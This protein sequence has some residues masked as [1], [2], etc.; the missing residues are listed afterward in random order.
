MKIVNATDSRLSHQNLRA[1]GAGGAVLALFELSG[2]ESPITA[3]HD[4]M[5]RCGGSPG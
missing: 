3:R 2:L 1:L 4:N 5:N